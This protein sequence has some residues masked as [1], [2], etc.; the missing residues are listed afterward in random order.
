MSGP[1][2]SMPNNTRPWYRRGD[3]RNW[4]GWV[5]LIVTVVVVVVL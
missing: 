5:V 4:Q 3:P 2:E 1:P